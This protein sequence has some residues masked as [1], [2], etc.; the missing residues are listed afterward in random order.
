MAIMNSKALKKDVQIG[1]SLL[2][3][4]LCESCEAVENKKASDSIHN[5]YLHIN[6]HTLSTTT[7]CRGA[8]L[9]RWSQSGQRL[10]GNAKE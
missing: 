4:F 9:D 6:F 2:S 7:V 3:Y 5:I 8:D 1:N 10:T